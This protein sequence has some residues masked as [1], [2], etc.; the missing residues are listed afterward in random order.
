MDSLS[1]ELRYFWMSTVGT[2]YFIDKSDLMSITIAEA[3][4]TKEQWYNIN[5]WKIIFKKPS[6]QT[7]NKKYK[8][9]MLGNEQSK[10]AVYKQASHIGGEAVTKHHPRSL[11]K[12]GSGY[13]ICPQWTK[14]NLSAIDKIWQTSV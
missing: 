1:L 2:I 12:S 6:Q 8:Q 3:I 14:L 9:F 10:D 13:I 11:Q 5:R 7:K 4:L